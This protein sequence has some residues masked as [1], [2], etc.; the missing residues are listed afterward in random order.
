M[1]SSLASPGVL[2]EPEPSVTAVAPVWHTVSVLLLL[3]AIGALSLRMSMMNPAAQ[4][5]HRAL[6]YL[7]SM[8]AEWLIVGFIAFKAPLRTLVG[9]FAPTWRSVLRDLGI[10][11][12]YLLA[13]QVILGTISAV[14]SRFLPSQAN[15]VLKNMV[16]HTA[17]EIALY[18]LLS[19]T[20]GICE[21]IM[22]RGYLQRQ[23]AAWT[24]NAIAAILLQGIVF[25]LAHG[26][27]GLSMVIVIA[28]FGCM[29]G[30]LAWWRK[31]LR[32]GMMAHF[33]QDGVGGIVLARFLPK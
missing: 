31:S 25:G 9:S 21:E 24:G 12:A 26:Y 10:A 32:P 17:L 29:F 11:I 18:L 15:A 1:H 8:A 3:G 4:G 30:W 23:F 6:G 14:L 27:Q 28:V 19:L 2:K 33:L 7:V 20:A 13:A 16:P 22:F 5:K